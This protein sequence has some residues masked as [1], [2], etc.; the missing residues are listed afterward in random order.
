MTSK[1]WVRGAPL[2]VLALLVLG[3]CSSSS[4]RTLDSQAIDGYIVK[5]AVFCDE[6]SSGITA[7]EGRLSCPK[8]T[9]L[10]TVSGGWDV[11]FD[12]T[13]ETSNVVF[14]GE[15]RAPASL[16]YV[17]PLSTVAVQM[18]STT[19][20]GYQADLWDQ[21]VR[22]LGMALG[23]DALDL[24]KDPSDIVNSQSLIRFNAQ[25]HQIIST[26]AR[27]EMEY[28]SAIAAFAT[29][30]SK[31]AQEGT[32]VGLQDNL[33]ETLAAI[34]EALPTDSYLMILTPTQIASSA[35]TV[36]A[37]NQIIDAAV[38]E[39]NPVTVAPEAAAPDT[40]V[41][42]TT[43]PVTVEEAAIELL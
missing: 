8:N 11:G 30:V 6:E 43:V 22:A 40:T 9:V 19:E 15:L 31:N 17:T 1:N 42:D 35:V 16:G 5:G 29:V 4:D 10:V 18:A 32:T 28:A 13:A 36:T 34:N 39:G 25:I 12:S 37:T 38:T 3:A 20:G 7:I 27:S 14:V 2:S 24:T 23:D 21:K 33:A 26:F 41:P